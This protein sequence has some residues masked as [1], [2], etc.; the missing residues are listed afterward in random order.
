[1]R[2]PT[3]RRLQP[4]DDMPQPQHRTKRKK[5]HS[6]EPIFLLLH[7]CMDDRLKLNVKILRWLMLH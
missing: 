5:I 2:K 3:C 7:F 4:F 1:M 6:S